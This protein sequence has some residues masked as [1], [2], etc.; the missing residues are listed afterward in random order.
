M[1]T[2]ILI[3]FPLFSFAQSNYIKL[4]EYSVTNSSRDTLF[5]LNDNFG[6]MI[7]YSWKGVS[8]EVE[9]IPT[10]LMVATLP[11]TERKRLK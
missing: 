1:K 6:N 4:S 2:F 5:L 3:L 8:S 7:R 9:K 11:S 10:I